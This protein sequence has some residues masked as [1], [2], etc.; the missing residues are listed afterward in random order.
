VLEAC[1][2]RTPVGLELDEPE[3]VAARAEFEKSREARGARRVVRVRR[4][5]G[6]S[7]RGG[8]DAVVECGELH[9]ICLEG[10]TIRGGVADGGELVD[11]AGEIRDVDVGHSAG[12]WAGASE[13]AGTGVLKRERAAVA[14]GR[15]GT[16]WYEVARDGQVCVRGARKLPR[17]V[18]RG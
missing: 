8:C 1:P 14:R 3:R 11:G 16:R 9:F 17:A 15:R 18:S 2:R 12:R 4:R 10:E 7:H 5:R 13:G 6:R